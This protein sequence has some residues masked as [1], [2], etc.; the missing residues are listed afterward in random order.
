MSQRLLSRDWV[1]TA[2][3]YATLAW[4][5]F[6]VIGTWFTILKYGI[7]LKGLFAVLLTFFFATFI[8]V[9]PFTGLIL[10]SLFVTPSEE[11]SPSVMFKDLI[12]R[13]MKRSLGVTKEVPQ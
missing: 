1:S 4:T 2:V 5:I 3:H 6:C 12:K 13:G 9:I 8:W 7:L 10:L 11:A